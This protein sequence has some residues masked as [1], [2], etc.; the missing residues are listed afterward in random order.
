MH[1][2]GKEHEMEVCGELEEETENSIY[3]KS[4]LYIWIHFWKNESK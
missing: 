2:V 1:D 3:V 4:T